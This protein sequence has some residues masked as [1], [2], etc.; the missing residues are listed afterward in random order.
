MYSALTVI[1]YAQL[2]FEKWHIC[3]NK[4]MYEENTF[5]ANVSNNTRVCIMN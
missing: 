3:K 2:S 1:E 5:P 4:N